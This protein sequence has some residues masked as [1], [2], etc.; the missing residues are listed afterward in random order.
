MFKIV[1]IIYTAKPEY[2]SHNKENIARVMSDLRKANHPGIKYATY[3]QE[4]GKTFMHFTHFENEEASKLLNSLP[5][6][7]QFQDEL[8]ANGIEV[9][10]KVDHL[11]LVDSSYDIF[12]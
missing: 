10:P 6:F 1:R 9:P 4:D 2:V 3:I 7:K 12:I 8:K 11:S 5:S